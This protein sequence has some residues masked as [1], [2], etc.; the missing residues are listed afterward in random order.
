MLCKLREWST[1]GAQ[2][3][4]EE[5]KDVDNSILEYMK[6]FSV[7][8]LPNT[9]PLPSKGLNSINIIYYLN[10]SNEPNTEFCFTENLD[11]FVSFVTSRDVKEGEELTQDYNNLSNNKEELFKQFPFLPN[12]K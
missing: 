4:T 6:N 2:I 12:K 1:F 7:P 8:C 3:S 5:L 10:H 9:Y 11:D